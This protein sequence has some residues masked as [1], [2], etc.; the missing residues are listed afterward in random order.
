MNLFGGKE[1][2]EFADKL[3]AEISRRV[4]PTPGG[5]P[6]A[7]KVEKALAHVALAAGEFKRAH[8]VNVL[9]QVRLSKAF[10]E[11][12]AALGYEDEFIRAATLRLAQSLSA[13]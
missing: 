11:K 6:P 1:L 5:T 4:P 8:K 10:Q 2:Q 3:A 7:Q 13:R 12:L 9:K